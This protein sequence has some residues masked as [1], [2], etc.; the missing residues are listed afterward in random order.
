M[1]RDGYEL[2]TLFWE[3]TLQC[4]ARC[5]FCGSRCENAACPGELTTDEAV[6]AFEDIARDIGTE[7][8]T[9][10]VTGGE[11]LMRR[12]IFTVMGRCRELGFH[13]GMVTNGMLI[14]D[15]TVEK[16]RRSGMSTVSVSI[17]GPEEMHDALRGVKG[18][19]DRAMNGLKKLIAA[20]FL[21]HVQVTTVVNSRNFHLLED[22]YAMLRPL[23]LDSWRV[24]I[25]DGIGRARDDASILL[26][27]AQ[28]NAYAAFVK[29]H[30][31]DEALP[32]VTSCSHFLGGGDDSLGRDTF[33]CRTGINVGSILANG[34]IFVC[35]NVP[36]R[37]ELIE[38]SVRST[39]FAD[40]W[41]NGFAYFR[42]PENRR[43]EACR[44]CGYWPACMG[45]SMHTW[46]WDARCPGFCYREHMATVQPTPA[47]SDVLPLLRRS[48]PGLKGVR[49]TPRRC[50]DARLVFTPAAAADMHKLFRWGEAHP[51]NMSEQMGCLIGRQ[52]SDC[53]LVEFVSQV[54]L[55]KRD[56]DLAAFSQQSLCS[57]VEELNAVR[58]HY[59]DDACRDLRLADEPCSLIGFVHSHPEPLTVLP[60]EP[61]VS[62]H[63]RLF[64]EMGLEWTL[65]VNPQ[66]RMLAAYWG[67]DMENAATELLCS[68][69]DVE[70]WR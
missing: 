60:S 38:G 57:A 63:E 53:T 67:K 23:G 47:L 45:D 56:T 54:Y 34:D 65:I 39:S 11:P 62:L 69:T 43:G 31:R 68:P 15:D 44:E 24:A 14:D 9:I 13:W 4:N 19:F 20:D 7:G 16:M 52:L 51:L 10:N 41:R 32:V 49:F 42:D 27:R 8:I 37:P 12:D 3:C 36:R 33:M 35:P 26:D 18:G 17:D 46:D 66:R 48:C 30:S 28:L 55:E 25:V 29:A 22:M 59:F 61:D 21:E 58:R 5:V 1:S 6:R 40:A 2:R 70:K 50:G 64:G